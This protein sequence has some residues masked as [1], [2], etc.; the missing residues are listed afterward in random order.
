MVSLN[1]ESFW[2]GKR[3]EPRL[4]KQKR[5][6]DVNC[7]P[8]IKRSLLPST[9][10]L[11]IEGLSENKICIVSHVANSYNA[12]SILLQDTHCINVDRLVILNYNLAGWISSKKHGLVTFVHEQLKWTFADHTL[13]G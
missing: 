5:R 10:K 2:G 8:N 11:N 6:L 7:R 1:M 3:I 12:L 9:L 4:Q 13:E